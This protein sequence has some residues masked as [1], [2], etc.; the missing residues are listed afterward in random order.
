MKKIGELVTLY[1]KWMV[2]GI[3][4][5]LSF[6]ACGSVLQAQPL[7]LPDPEFLDALRERNIIE[8][9]EEATIQIMK[10]F[11][12]FRYFR[13][14][15][16][17]LSSI[18]GIEH[19]MNLQVLEIYGSL[20]SDF[21]PPP[22]LSK[23]RRLILT[24]NLMTDLTIPDSYTL[25]ERLEL[26]RTMVSHLSLPPALSKLES[27]KMNSNEL[28]DFSLVG[29][30]PALERLELIGNRLSE[31]SLN[32][33]LEALRFL[34]LGSNQLSRF[35]V[36]GTLMNLEV[37][38]LEG[39]RL[40]SLLLSEEDLPL[41]ELYLA[42]NRLVDFEIPVQFSTLEM[43]D[44]SAN[45]LTKL[46]V[47]T[48]LQWLRNIVLTDNQI[49]A[50]LVP[51]GLP[52]LRQLNLENNPIEK[53]LLPIGTDVRRMRITGVD[54]SLIGF[55]VPLSHRLHEG[56]LELT[57]PEGRL[58]ERAKIDGTWADVTEAVSPYLV[59]TIDPQRFY[60]VLAE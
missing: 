22:S 25:L 34:G 28:E 18:E 55:Y 12:D 20:L 5:G 59:N 39:N 37:L 9:N 17:P 31:F 1:R 47:P 43:I 57:W 2:S 27:L 32:E 30:F 6:L 16:P 52:R 23:M 24:E 21:V 45:G 15:G 13:D 8:R 36:P 38:N 44:L 33:N 49:R 42:S 48:G 10:N 35:E 11:T 3:P 4:V 51:P 29:D 56:Q 26:S 46:R 60:R 54:R 14:S 58:Q 19:A 50:L 41:K 40:E 7:E 53:V